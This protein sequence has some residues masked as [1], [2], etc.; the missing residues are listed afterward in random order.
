MKNKYVVIDE[1]G[2]I[3]SAESF[4]E[5]AHCPA[6]FKIVIEREA[7]GIRPAADGKSNYLEVAK[8]FGFKWEP[9][10]DIGFVQYDHN[11]QLMMELVQRYARQLVQKIGFPVYEV[12]GSNFFDMDHPA[13]DAYAS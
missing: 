10:A 6:E 1:K 4:I 7:L 13:V 5:N 3:H 8:K 12:R 2:A 9:K 11:G